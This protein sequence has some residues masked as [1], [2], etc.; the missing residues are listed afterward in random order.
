M[1]TNTLRR[2]VKSKLD[3]VCK[4]YYMTAPDDAMYPH[5]VFSFDSTD[6]DDYFRNDY[7]MSVDVW[8]KLDQEQAEAMADAICDLLNAVN[9][10]QGTI[11]PTFYREARRNLPDEDK[12]IKHIQLDFTI[13]CYDYE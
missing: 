11:L 13:Q 1:R 10:P 9:D 2:L 8:C 5:V 7:D 4:S 6:L 12:D 3:T